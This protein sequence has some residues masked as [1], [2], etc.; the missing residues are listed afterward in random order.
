MTM[1][2]YYLI[3]AAF[4]VGFLICCAMV[5][6]NSDALS[7]PD[8]RR[9]KPMFNGFF[10]DKITGPSTAGDI[11]MIAFIA[12]I[13][14]AVIARIVYVIYK[15]IK[16]LKAQDRA[17]DIDNTAASPERNDKNSFKNILTFVISSRSRWIDRDF[18]REDEEKRNRRYKD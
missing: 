12:I 5:F 9:I 17:D 13:V 16:K 18:I 14:I 3:Y 2:K 6:L 7:D 8:A 15:Y 4:A 1:K 10:V 11:A